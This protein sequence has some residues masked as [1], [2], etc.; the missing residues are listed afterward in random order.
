MIRS[1][2][3][4]IDNNWGDKLNP[5]LIKLISG[6]DVVYSKKAGHLKYIVVGSILHYADN[7]SIVWGSGL[8]SPDHQPQGK[9]SIKAVRGPLT[10][11]RLI[12]LGHDCPEVF[13]DPALLYPRYYK[14]N[15]KK[16]HKIGIIPHYKDKDNP[17]IKKQNIKVIDIQGEINKVVD[18]VCSCE[19]IISSSLHGVILADAYGIPGYWIKLSDKLVGGN[20]KFKD[21]LI[22][23]CRKTDPI[24]ITDKTSIIDIQNQFYDYQINIDLNQLM[25]SCPFSSFNK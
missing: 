11:N 17:W 19:T 2:W 14:P 10:R 3:Y 21:Y 18:E 12:S 7:N 5:V 25:E 6:H 4:N 9:P 8:I 24:I 1:R 15:I 20:F 16:E 22:S 13:G 23:V